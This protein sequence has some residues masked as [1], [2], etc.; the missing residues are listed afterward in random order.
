MEPKKCGMCNCELTDRPPLYFAAGGRVCVRCF[1][2]AS[3]I[4]WGA[5]L[6]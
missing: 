3:G 6:A 5:V 2:A 4:P 1:V